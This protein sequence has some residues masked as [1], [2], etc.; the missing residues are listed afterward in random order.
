VA[1]FTDLVAV[2]IAN[3]QARL[4]LTASRKRIVEAADDTRRRLERDLHDGAQQRLVSL[5][6]QLRTAA[7]LVPPDAS[8][9]RTDH[10]HH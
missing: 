1:D 9:L 8:V 4:D 5:A 7:M 10:G 3:A 6:I 2:A